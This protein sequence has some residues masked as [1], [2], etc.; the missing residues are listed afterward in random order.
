MTRYP[1]HAN[2]KNNQVFMYINLAISL[3]SDLG[4]DLELPNLNSFGNIST[5]GLIEGA[6][7][8][9]AAKRAYLGCYYLSS[10]LVSFLRLESQAL[11]HFPI[12]GLS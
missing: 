8:T 3:T 11:D 1:L 6:S 7:F 9:D 10:A 5:Q 12:T 2:P 4:L